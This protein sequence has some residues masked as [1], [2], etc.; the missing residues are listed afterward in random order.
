M[1]FVYVAIGF[2]AGFACAAEIGRQIYNNKMD[3]IRRIAEDM[4]KPTNGARE[5]I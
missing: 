5:D 1:W 4:A 3:E 2:I